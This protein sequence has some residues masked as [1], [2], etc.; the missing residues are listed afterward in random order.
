MP[1]NQV[2]WRRP[3]GM[4]AGW[5]VL[6]RGRKRAI[7]RMVVRCAIRMPRRCLARSGVF[8][9]ATRGHSHVCR[10]SGRGQPSVVPAACAHKTGPARMLIVDETHHRVRARDLRSGEKERRPRQVACC[11]RLIAPAGGRDIQPPTANL[12]LKHVRQ[13]DVLLEKSLRFSMPTLASQAAARPGPTSEACHN[14][15]RGG[16]G[17]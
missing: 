15:A 11:V 12:Q 8:A 7:E 6:A 3:T 14:R 2:D 13:A 5:A 10:T 17:A 1:C 16:R 4:D 9:A